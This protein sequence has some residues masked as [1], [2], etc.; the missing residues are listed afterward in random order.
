MNTEQHFVIGVPVKC[1]E[2]I[3]GL[4]KRVVLD[5]TGTS[6]THLVVGP[7]YH[8]SDDRLVPVALAH[9]VVGQVGLS[10][11][12]AQFGELDAS[13]E[14][15]LMATAEELDEAEQARPN[16][17]SPAGVGG[18]STPGFLTTP[19]AGSGHNLIVHF[20]K[21]GEVEIHRGQPVSALDGPVGQVRGLIVDRGTQRVTHLLVQHGHLWDRADVS[22]PVE[23]IR[24]VMGTV[25]L[26]MNTADVAD[27]P[28]VA[29]V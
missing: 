20:L 12:A 8:Q 14:I 24:S 9:P 26:T 11:S 7:A 23:R 21:H 28:E 3:V 10:C 27:L 15:H 16:H 22:V 29:R 6:L 4:L 18:M 17:R 19:N 5:P 25:Q 2:T 13:M 1:G